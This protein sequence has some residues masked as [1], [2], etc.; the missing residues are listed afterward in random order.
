MYRALFLSALALAAGGLGCS[1][2][3][4]GSNAPSAITRQSLA[5][6]WII[7]NVA[8][9]EYEVDGSLRTIWDTTYAV[10]DSSEF[11]V[12]GMDSIKY[13]HWER[14][15]QSTCFEDWY[16]GPYWI[17]GNHLTGE[18]WDGVD[19]DPGNGCV[20]RWH[21]QVSMGANSMQ[22]TSLDT[23]SCT[24]GYSYEWRLVET[25]IR[26]AGAVP[27]LSWPA[28]VCL[29]AYKRPEGRRHR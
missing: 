1:D 16:A 21:T 9:S 11:Y 18:W 15:G 12:I 28:Q 17:E 2:D 22:I 8:E 24:D 23:I 4:T 3:D 25:A 29:T 27:P 6:T 13:Y 14:E 7:T 19:D 26:Y 5:G 10:T 20:E